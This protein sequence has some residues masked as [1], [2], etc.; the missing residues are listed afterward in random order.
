M[1]AQCGDVLVG[2]PVLALDALPVELLADRAQLGQERLAPVHAFACAL[3]VRVD[4]G[5][6]EAAEVEPLG[7]ARPVPTRLAG[8][9]SDL[10]GLL[11]TDLG[12]VA[13]A[14]GDSLMRRCGRVR[15]RVSHRGR[16]VGG[17]HQ[18]S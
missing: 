3:R 7:E 5:K 9:L 17:R 6:V 18:L 13:R 15:G 8:G 11:L 16:V 1:S 10:P 4:Q 2:D 14:R 12:A